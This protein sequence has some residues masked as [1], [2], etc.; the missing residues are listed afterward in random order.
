[1][2]TSLDWLKGHI[3]NIVFDE[4]LFR[5]NYGENKYIFGAL[6]PIE[7]DEVDIFAI[8]SIYDT[9][10]DLNTKIKYSFNA[11]VKCNPS[12]NLMEHKMFEKPSKNEM[13]ALYYIENMIFR[14]STLW[15]MLA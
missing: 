12:E 11:V 9:I 5:V 2:G 6:Y 13:K 14:T 15:D 10:I 8:S 4:A 7:E 3:D 1:M